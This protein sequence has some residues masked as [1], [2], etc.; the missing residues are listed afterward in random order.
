MFDGQNRAVHVRIAL[1]AHQGAW[2]PGAY[3]TANISYGG[4]RRLAVPSEAVA[5]DG[6]RSYV[7]LAS[8]KQGKAVFK[9]LQVKTGQTANGFV[10]IVSGLVPQREIALGG[11]YILMSQWKK[12]DAEQ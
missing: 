10:E 11:A 3:V 2:V 1:G 9:P 4:V 12:A 8:R 5:A 7:F 6:D